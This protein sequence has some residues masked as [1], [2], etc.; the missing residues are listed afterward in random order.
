MELLLYTFL[1]LVVI[2]FFSGIEISFFSANRFRMELLS[3]QGS[4]SGRVL[5]D[6]FRRPGR[7]LSMLLTGLNISLILYAMVTSRLLEP[8][9]LRVLGWDREDH[10]FQ[11]LLLQTTLSTLLVLVVGEYLPKVIFQRYADRALIWGAPFLNAFSKLLA[12]VIW[13]LEGLTR[14][15]LGSKA[16]PEEQVLFTKQDL[17]RYAVDNLPAENES[18]TELD[19]EAFANALEFNQLRVREFM[20]PRTDIQAVSH[21]ATMAEVRQAFV[22]T[23]HSRL[24]VYRETL[25]DILGY[26]Q[27]L[28]ALRAEG[29]VLQ[30]IRPIPM[31]PETMP[32]NL[33]LNEFRTQQT[34]IAVVV[35][36]FG[37]TAGLTTLEDLVEEV[38]GE[39]E[40]EHDDEEDTSLVEEELPNGTYRF[41]ARLEVDYLNRTYGLTLPEG[42]DY[43]T[44]GGLVLYLAGSLPQAGENFQDECYKYTVEAARS[45]RLEVLHI[46]PLVVEES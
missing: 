41:S 7:F 46:T 2:A 44:L 40:D 20:I 31:V 11:L 35:D 23:E 21:E 14:L 29:E 42:D 25:D 28:D 5:S 39:I 26:I 34:S 8:W 32:A 9:L 36:E 15:L 6:F 19:A 33:L 1:L 38:F 22:E 12:P 13:L 3:N 27:V 24:L 18:E 45:T 16:Q 30:L 43:A 17:Y 37:G 10:S 4:L